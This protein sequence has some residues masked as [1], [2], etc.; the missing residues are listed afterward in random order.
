[1][2][3][4]F[5]KIL[6][7]LLF[8]I[9][10]IT[11]YYVSNNCLKDYI[12][13]CKNSCNVLVPYK[14][15]E[16]FNIGISFTPFTM[17]A[18]EY[19]AKLNDMFKLTSFKLPNELEYSLD[20]KTKD[21]CST[22]Y[23]PTIIYAMRKSRGL[24]PE[25]DVIYD[26][27][28]GKIKN[29]RTEWD[30]SQLNGLI[31]DT[32]YGEN[33][34][35]P[36]E[37]VPSGQLSRNFDDLSIIPEQG[38]FG[39]VIPPMTRYNDTYTNNSEDSL[40]N[41]TTG[42]LPLPG[43][44]VATCFENS[45]MMGNGRW[46]DTGGGLSNQVTYPK[47]PFHFLTPAGTVV[48]RG[49]NYGSL[50]RNG[51][52]TNN[53]KNLFW[54][55]SCVKKE[56]E[57]MSLDGVGTLQNEYY[58]RII[59]ELDYLPLDLLE[60]K[61]RLNG[62]T[63]S[64]GFG[65]EDY[66]GLDPDVKLTQLNRILSAHL[67]TKFTGLSNQRIASDTRPVSVYY[68]SQLIKP[69]ETI[70]K[71][72]EYDVCGINLEKYLIDLPMN[73]PN[74][75]DNGKLIFK[76]ASTGLKNLRTILS[77]GH[78][79]VQ[80]EL[81]NSDSN[82]LNQAEFDDLTAG[83]FYIEKIGLVYRLF[84]VI[85]TDPAPNIVE[86]QELGISTDPAHNIVQLKE[87]GSNDTNDLSIKLYKP[88]LYF[89]VEEGADPGPI[90]LLNMNNI[91]SYRDTISI[92]TNIPNIVLDP[93]TP[94]E[95]PL[96]TCNDILNP[97]ARPDIFELVKAS[98]VLLDPNR[99]YAY[100]VRNTCPQLLADFGGLASTPI[101]NM[102]G[103]GFG[104]TIEFNE[105]PNSYTIRPPLND[106]KLVWY[107]RT[108]PLQS[109]YFPSRS[110]RTRQPIF[111]NIEEV[112]DAI[113]K[114]NQKILLTYGQL[115][116]DYL[117]LNPHRRNK[118]VINIVVPPSTP[119]T[120]ETT[121][122]VKE[123]NEEE[124][125]IRH[126]LGSGYSKNQWYYLQ[127]NIKENQRCTANEYDYAE[128]DLARMLVRL[129]IQ[130]SL[131]LLDLI[132]GVSV[133]YSN[134][135]HMDR[136]NDDYKDTLELYRVA[137]QL[138]TPYGNTLKRA[139]SALPNGGFPDIRHREHI[140]K[141]I[142]YG[143]IGYTRVNIVATDETIYIARNTQIFVYGR[144]NDDI[145]TDE[146]LAITTIDRHIVR[147]NISNIVYIGV[148]TISEDRSGALVLGRFPELSKR[149]T[150]SGAFDINQ[151]ACWLVGCNQ[152]NLSLQYPFS[153]SDGGQFDALKGERMI[154]T[155][156]LGLLTTLN[157][158]NFI[159]PTREMAILPAN[160]TFRAE[161]GAEEGVPPEPCVPFTEPVGQPVGQQDSSDEERQAQHEE[162][163]SSDGED[164]P[165]WRNRRCASSKTRM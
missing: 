109:S 5:K 77:Y 8:I 152:N 95:F 55:A 24:Y 87:L 156:A 42:W 50:R 132:D 58:S 2:V 48:N 71:W 41:Y 56:N 91:D 165:D 142:P 100:L 43:H 60:D 57:S 114:T 133:K 72:Q 130:K 19:N 105:T 35:L 106:G 97:V 145:T 59:L 37:N 46:D 124:N 107:P 150:I 78:L 17:N 65:I 75:Q 14:N 98:R 36:G 119:L 121:Y 63:E 33:F 45:N 68:E 53:V 146:I 92:P 115:L 29:V 140:S 116:K 30:K 76:S 134:L 89:G 135:A 125:Q 137:S 81:S 155:R 104:Q 128:A 127:K 34:P 82:N 21:A 161:G 96:T 80:S 4:F 151:C 67:R 18:D 52:K 79:S 28:G 66:S 153:N 154:Q 158:G 90:Q 113:I 73:S 10:G 164:N 69:G 157:I 111:N 159:R 147:I 163:Y 103:P 16:T 27:R 1:M 26:A 22:V 131:N 12:K 143:H 144:I 141:K 101:R 39:L 122:F 70:D 54:V 88:I 86:L 129:D 44:F 85:S 25:E 31:G 3:T 99:C 93:Y 38:T 120:E 162:D 64:N 49:L 83:K 23:S 139:I 6:I 94:K 160:H 74:P 149:N 136:I 47:S 123:E 110:S 118:P 32:L 15:I 108:N 61:A 102:Y 11:L 62:F 148:R 138:D 117:N 20:H 51:R 40:Y 9:I 7:Y 13:S 84:R 112:K 126:S